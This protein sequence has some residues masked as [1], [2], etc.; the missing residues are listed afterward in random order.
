MPNGIVVILVG[1]Q[2]L[3]QVGSL[4][5]LGALVAGCRPRA[6]DFDRQW[7]WGAPNP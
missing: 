3:R 2:A 6:G 1:F 7:A 4:A 5:G